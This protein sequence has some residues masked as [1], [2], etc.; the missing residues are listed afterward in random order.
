MR[1]A[2]RLFQ[3]VQLLRRRRITTAARLAEDRP[4]PRLEFLQV[5]L[6]ERDLPTYGFV[7]GV[8]RTSLAQRTAARLG[9]TRDELLG[10]IAARK[11][12]MGPEPRALLPEPERAA[13]ASP[14]ALLPRD[15][16]ASGAPFGAT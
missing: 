15:A 4:I 13:D 3:I 11:R 10:L 5:E 16:E 14:P 9:V 6:G 8:A 2:D 1:R 12:A 7:P